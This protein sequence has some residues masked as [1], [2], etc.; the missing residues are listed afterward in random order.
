M[1][2]GGH[3]SLC[4]AS[5]Q[6]LTLS[7]SSGGVPC[8]NPYGIYHA[9]FDRMHASWTRWRQPRPKAA[10]LAQDLRSWRALQ[11]GAGECVLHIVLCQNLSHRRSV[12]CFGRA[13]GVTSKV[14]TRVYGAFVRNKV[15]DIRQ[16]MINEPGKRSSFSLS[17]PSC[18]AQN[19]EKRLGLALKTYVLV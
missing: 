10:E 19:K 4:P 6:A 2:S 1:R 13:W 16:H 9:A 8:A 3:S 5:R 18:A 17:Y 14:M 11:R 15:L 7:G 12:R